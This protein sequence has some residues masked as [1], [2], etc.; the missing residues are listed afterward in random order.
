VLHAQAKSPAP[1]LD[2]ATSKRVAESVVSQTARVRPGELVVLSG[3]E[4]DLRFLEDLAVAVRKAGARSIIDYQSN[5]LAR[6]LYD[7][8][9]AALDTL[10]PQLK[11]LPITDVF[12]GTDYL[13][14]STFDGV[15]P[16]RLAARQKADAPFREALKSWKGRSVGLGNG[17][18]PTPGNARQAGM[19]LGQLTALYRAGL[20]VDYAALE[21]TAEAIRAELEHGSEVHL[22]AANGTDLTAKIAGQKPY[23][24][25]G[26]IS[27]ADRG[28]NLAQRVAYL[29]AGEVYIVTAPG[30]ARGTL[31]MDRTWYRN[32]PI[33]KLRVDVEAGKVRN[34]SADAG[35]AGLQSDYEKAGAGKDQVGVLDI[36]INPAIHPPAGSHTQPWSQAGMVTIAIG[37][38]Q[39]AGGDNAGEFSFPIQLT[40]ATLVI[41]GTTLVDHG[42]L[43]TPAAAA[44][45]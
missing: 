34:L 11:T 10:A 33:T 22:T 44:G 31:V 24:S 6:R 7:E 19:T 41:D 2:A 39:W 43:V 14:P 30:S 37:N 25:D 36:G 26:V 28:G 32:Q 4:R 15:D 3:G 29:P 35:A 5:R 23:T 42:K 27:D 16:T 21:R 8:V 17:L 38:N 1:V 18:Y 20:G 9:P 12:I 40:G 45:R 13:D